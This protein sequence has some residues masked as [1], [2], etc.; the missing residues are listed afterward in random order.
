MA[1]I[2]VKIFP[3][4]YG[5]SFLVS[6]FG[7]KNIHILIDM[8]FKKTYTDS[9]RNEL[10]T[11]YDSEEEISLLVFTHIDDDH[12][13]GGRAFFENEAKIDSVNKIN[14][15][16]IWHNGYKQIS[17]CKSENFE[18]IDKELSKHLE[19]IIEQGYPRELYD[20]EDSSISVSNAISLATL[21]EEKGYKDKWNTKFAGEAIIV[22]K[23]FLAKTIDDKVDIILLSPTRECLDQL[24]DEWQKELQERGIENESVTLSKEMN[25]GFEVFMCRKQEEQMKRKILECAYDEEVDGLH[26]EE[27]VADTSETNASS[28]AFIIKYNKKQML[29]LGDASADVVEESLREYLRINGMEKIKFDLVKVA[30]HGSKGNTSSSLLE[31]FES[32]NYVFSTNGKGKGR[33]HKHPDIE[34]IYRIVT[35]NNK[36]KK[37]IFNYK[38]QWI[39]DI[40]NNA[41]MKEKYNYEI[42]YTNDLEEDITNKITTIDI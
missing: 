9:I 13:L 36:H 5:D 32:D 22:D 42:E 18:Q 6:F 25:D 8:G 21:L 33:G 27:F 39:F 38:P 24:K 28:I 35:S 17:L 2:Q 4:S 7:E 31:L 1:E 12:I 20:E 11:I 3:A 41:D 30:H 10:K 19:E 37:L 29:F 34:T 40:I 15:K 14:V 16:E 23:K 26:D